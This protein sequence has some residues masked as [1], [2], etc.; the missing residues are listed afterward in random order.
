[1]RGTLTVVGTGISLGQVTPQVAG[2][3]EHAEKVLFL[4]ADPVTASWVKE[5]N[6][7]A[8][9]LFLFYDKQKDRL[10]TYLEMTDRIL[11]FVRQDLVVCAVFYGHPGVFVFPSH[12]AVLRAR[13]EGYNATMLPGI[14]AEDCLFADL[15]I[16]P[17]RA[18]C[19]SFEATDFLIHRRRYDPSIGLILWQIGVLGRTGYEGVTSDENIQI[20][21]EILGHEY[22]LDHE[23]AIYEAAQYPVCD[24]VIDW[25]KLCNLARTART[26]ISTLYVPPKSRSTPDLDMLRRLGISLEYVRKREEST[27]HY[28]PVRP[29]RR[30]FSRPH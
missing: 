29:S 2:V 18:G 1:M 19:Q 9:D 17:G 27:I 10:T 14:S 22:G 15:G 20:L 23:V 3:I 24:P 11:H 5:C 4:V 28:D 25:T 26:P 7:T 30:Q 6:C 12:E 8:E 16:D 21:A 13:A